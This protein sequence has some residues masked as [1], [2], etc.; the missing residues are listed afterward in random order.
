MNIRTNFRQTLAMMREALKLRSLA[1]FYGTQERLFSTIYILGTAL[2]IAFTM[3]MAVVYYIKLAPI[4][5]ERSE[6]AHV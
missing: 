1:T 5:P 4:Y 3:V 6:E 2:A